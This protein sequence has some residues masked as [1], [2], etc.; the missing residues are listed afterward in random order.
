M[1]LAKRKIIAEFTGPR[2][3]SVKPM[4]MLH[5]YAQPAD[6]SLLADLNIHQMKYAN[7]DKSVLNALTTMPIR[8]IKLPVDFGFTQNDNLIYMFGWSNG[9]PNMV[10][11]L[12]QLQ[13]ILCALYILL[14]LYF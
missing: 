5:K 11:L 10:K 13:I 12:N 1:L 7:T 3:L 4:L 6:G 2:E 14:L 8:T 9:E